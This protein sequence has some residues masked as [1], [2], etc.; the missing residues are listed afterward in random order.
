MNIDTIDKEKYT[1][2]YE[3]GSGFWN[4]REIKHFFTVLE[5]YF[6]MPEE[7]T[8]KNKANMIAALGMT[9]EEYV[10]NIEWI[11][12]LI[13]NYH[14]AQGSMDCLGHRM[15]QIFRLFFV[16]PWIKTRKL[17][18]SVTMTPTPAT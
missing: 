13:R 8:A 16:D 3:I 14:K 5:T 18:L 4:T 12:N 10:W 15:F 9:V 11:E 7:E 6:N 1:K 17:L 2:P